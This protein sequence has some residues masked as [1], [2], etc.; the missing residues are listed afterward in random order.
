MS[1]ALSPE[2]I[3]SYRE[4]GYVFPIDILGEAEAAELRR[5]FHGL[6]AR[7]GGQLSR[8]TNTRVH[9]LVTWL[10]DL[11]RDARILDPIEDLIG[12]DIL[13]W[14]SG[15]FA[16]HPG[17]GT[18]VSW[19]QDGAYWNMPSHETVS[20]W[21]AFTPS[22]PESGCMRVVRGSHKEMLQHEDRCNEK[23]L[24]MRGQEVAVEVDETAAV[25]IILKPGQ[26]SLHHPLI[27]HGS[28]PNRSNHPRVGYTIRYR[29]AHLCPSFPVKD[30]A[31][32]V[33]GTDR[34]GHFDLEPT[35]QFDFAPEAVRAHTDSVER[36]AKNYYTGVPKSRELDAPMASRFGAAR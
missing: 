28:N 34:Y 22:T 24:L 16:K 1:K 27:V 23:N 9:L 2:Q 29:P 3:A 19:H 32:L 15:F 6:E 31:T 7:E 25:D 26:V 35:P 12:P 13:C 8:R 18:F 36:L 17:D 30:T 4:N 10:N 14:A 33:R 5:K 11:I 21:I 20:V